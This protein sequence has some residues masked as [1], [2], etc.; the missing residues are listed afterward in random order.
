MMSKAKQ[1][2]KSLLRNAVSVARKSDTLRYLMDEATLKSPRSTAY[3][4]L[5]WFELDRIYTT[6]RRQLQA[7]VGWRYGVSRIHEVAYEGFDAVRAYTT[8]KDKTY[9]D[10]GCGSHHPFGVSTVM[11]LNGVASAI[12]TDLADT[13]KQR[14]A[15]AL[16]DLLCDCIASPGKWNWNGLSADEFLKR[17]ADFDLDALRAGRLL[18]GIRNIPFQHIVGDFQETPIHQNSVDVMTSRS[19]L[20][21]FLDFNAAAGRLFSIMR[22]GGVAFHHIDLSDPRS[23]VNSSFHPWSFLA[24]DESWANGFPIRVNRLRSSEIRA[25]L[26]RAGFEILRYE[27]RSKPMPVGFKEQIMG[28]FKDMP[29]EELNIMGVFSVIRKP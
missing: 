4:G 27:T 19:V 24:E 21:F 3:A 8:L 13:D 9:C 17:T 25:C 14:A 12:A 6:S 23:H 2:I 15:E 28:R 20:Q 7:Q 10:L 16:A 22:S 26:E 11:Y 5:T 1:M 18:D 29:D